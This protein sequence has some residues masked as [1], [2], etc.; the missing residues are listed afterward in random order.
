[1]N[2]AVF[3]HY[4]GAALDREYDNALKILAEMLTAYRARWAEQSAQ[5]RETIACVFDV[6]YG[7][8]SP[9]VGTC[10]NAATIS[11]RVCRHDVLDRVGS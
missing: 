4:G 9:P 6:P 11:E 2:P 1:M 7:P 3:C 5:A 10:S 8:L